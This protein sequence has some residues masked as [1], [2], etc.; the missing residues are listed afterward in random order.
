MDNSNIIFLPSKNEMNISYWVLTSCRLVANWGALL[1]GYVGLK[2]LI[3][4]HMD[5]R[6]IVSLGHKLKLI[7]FLAYIVIKKPDLFR[8]F[9]LNF[10]KR[11]FHGPNVQ[12]LARTCVCMVICYYSLHYTKHFCCKTFLEEHVTVDV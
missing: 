3:H 10:S 12:L 8:W 1:F 2:I 9:G 6:L 11:V 4:V 5:I 7:L